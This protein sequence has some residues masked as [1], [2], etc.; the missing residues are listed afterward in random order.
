MTE[1]RMKELR[2]YSQMPWFVECLDEIDRL[3]AFIDANMR[4]CD[5]NCADGDGEC[6]CGADAYN[7]SADEILEGGK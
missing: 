7:K 5:D 4:E 2:T 3:R 1:E 6:V